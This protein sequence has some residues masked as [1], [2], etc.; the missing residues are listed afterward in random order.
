MKNEFV[1]QSLSAGPQRLI[2][3][4]VEK[5]GSSQLRIA[6][7]KSKEKHCVLQL[8]IPLNETSDNGL[9]GIVGC[10]FEYEADVKTAY[11]MARSGD[12]SK[13]EGQDLCVVIGG[14][15]SSIYIKKFQHVSVCRCTQ[16]KAIE[17]ELGRR[18][19]LLSRSDMRG[20]S[21]DYIESQRTLE[22]RLNKLKRK[23]GYYE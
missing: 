20:F 12:F 17:N 21:K 11:S 14:K 22:E 4:K 18:G 13:I 3:D 5:V 6:F 19:I 8:V 16:F 10:L 9:L 15:E 2:I 7:R 23:R 1:K